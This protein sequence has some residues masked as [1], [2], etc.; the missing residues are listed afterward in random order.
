VLE[1]LHLGGRE[2]DIVAEQAGEGPVELFD[3]EAVA[4]PVE[5]LVT[6][7]VLEG[8]G[9][10]RAL[11]GVPGLEGGLRERGREAEDAGAQ[12]LPG[13]LLDGALRVPQVP[14]EVVGAGVDVTGAAGRL[15]QPAGPVRVVEM[16]ATD[17][18][19]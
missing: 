10:H 18:D 4:A 12:I 9:G 6:D 2:L 11:H 13:Q 1:L 15:P 8:L 7:D 3:A 19:G 14:G 5:G 16:L 17:L